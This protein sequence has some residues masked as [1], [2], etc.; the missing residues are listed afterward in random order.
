MEI[1]S[2]DKSKLNAAVYSKNDTA[3]AIE[4]AGRSNLL[5][6]PPS[7]ENFEQ[8]YEGKKDERS[9]ARIDIIV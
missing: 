2:I 9:P 4:K 1:K 3:R 6:R 7:D 8:A 5:R